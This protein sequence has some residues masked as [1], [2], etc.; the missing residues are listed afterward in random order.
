MR[1][2]TASLLTRGVFTID[3]KS[4]PFELAGAGAGARARL[5]SSRRRR[6]R[7]REELEFHVRMRA[8]DYERDGAPPPIAVARAKERFGNL[9]RWQDSGYDIRGG[10][11]METILQDLRYGVRLLRKQPGFSII[12]ILTLALGIG[13][14]T[15]IATSSR[16][17]DTAYPNE[18]SSNC[19][20]KCAPNSGTAGTL[21]SVGYRPRRHPL[22]E[23]C[24]ACGRDVENHLQAGANR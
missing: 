15:A 2:D 4:C 23:E 14:T 24:A 16:C 21:R 17:G 3:L 9:A 18:G 12:A 11:V 19:S 13:M 6:W 22:D 8:E 7:D 10:G 1:S 20:L 5:V